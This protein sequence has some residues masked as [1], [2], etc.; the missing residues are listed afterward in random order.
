MSAVIAAKR[1]GRPPRNARAVLQRVYMDSIVLCYRFWR[2]WRKENCKMDWF[3]PN[4]YPILI[5]TECSY[6]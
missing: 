2:E 6:E 1:A 4:G 3:G 5:H